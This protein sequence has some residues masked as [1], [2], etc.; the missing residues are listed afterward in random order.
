[1]KKNG[2]GT[3]FCILLGKYL[4]YC[5]GGITSIYRSKLKTRQTKIIFA[6]WVLILIF[7][8]FK[9]YLARHSNILVDTTIFKY[10]LIIIIA[11]PLL[12]LATKFNIPSKMQRKLKRKKVYQRMG[13][14]DNFPMIVDDQTDGN[15]TTYYV[16]SNGQALEIFNRNTD[17]LEHS[18]TE[19]SKQY[20]QLVKIKKNDNDRRFFEIITAN[21]AL[22]KFYN[23]N[24]E[25]IR[26]YIRSDDIFVG[27]SHF[28]NIVINFSEIPHLF[29][30]GETH[31][32]K[33]NVTK[34]IILQLLYKS[35]HKRIDIFVI[36]FKSGLD[37]T[38]VKSI[39]KV[40]KEYN[41]ILKLLQSL[42]KEMKRREVLLEK[43]E[44]ENIDEYNKTASNQLHRIYL[45]ADEAVDAVS[46]KDDDPI[47]D[48]L[49]QLARK[50]RAGGIHLILT[51]QLP[52]T[53]TF[54]N[55]LK[56][57]IPMR[58]CGRFA[59]ESA[60]RIVIDSTKASKL[61][62]IK[63]RMLYKLGADTYEMQTPKVSNQLITQ[64]VKANKNKMKINIES[65]S[66][67]KV[68]LEKPEKKF[69]DLNEIK[70][71]KV[72]QP[73]KKSPK[74]KPEK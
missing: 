72:K 35:L 54:G 68:S 6:T 42:T 12:N 66:D 36:D 26:E 58:I 7:S 59:D 18:F 8:I 51:T 21:K 11:F 62:E 64:F 63:G 47:K 49:T 73:F 9:M 55:Q 71:I 34:N 70:N 57:N 52:S 53:K 23:W 28:G 10:S 31:S 16:Y 19:F 46:G 32:G 20:C 30:A 48:A 4:Y 40:H 14:K 33:G 45:I 1:M 5:V 38:P 25:L 39:I 3:L 44:V 43:V 41:D 74:N 24:E 67:Q 61:P 2:L 27:I 60:S 56:N 22:I 37:Y 65:N 50:S 13:I 15:L 69:Y 29:I 17:L